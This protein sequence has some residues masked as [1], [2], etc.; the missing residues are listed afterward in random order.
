L[1]DTVRT[2]SAPSIKEKAHGV[3]T[4]LAKA[5]K[6]AKV[7]EIPEFST[8]KRLELLKEVHTEAS[9]NASHALAKAASTASLL[10]ASSLYKA[11]RTTYRE[12]ALVYM[13]TQEAW[14][15]GEIKMQESFFIDWVHWCQS[16]A[17]A[18]AI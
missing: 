9:R 2:T 10:I 17:A 6:R 1:L 8:A 12:I 15:Q 16:H 4:S 3:I 13:G 7:D 5:F 18:A 14:V 11:D